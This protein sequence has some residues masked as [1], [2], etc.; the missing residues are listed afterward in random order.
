MNADT[1]PE[2]HLVERI[3]LGSVLVDNRHWADASQLSD[4]DFVLSGHQ[5]IFRRMRQLHSAGAEIDEMSLLLMLEQHREIDKVGGMAYIS[6]LGDGIVE[7]PNIQYFVNLL[8]EAAVKR[9]IGRRAELIYKEATNG[10]PLLELLQLV[11][12]LNRDIAPHSDAGLEVQPLKT[13]FAEPSIPTEYIWEGHLV[14]GTVSAVVAKPK[15]GKSTFARNLCLAVSKGEEFLGRATRKG[16]C[17]YLA[18]EERKQEVVADFRA[19]GANGEEDIGIFS[20]PTPV[21]GMA[22]LVRKILERKPCLVVID[23]LFRI[24]K[25]KDE[26]A[27]AETYAALGPLIEVARQ[28]NT[29]VLMTHHSGKAEKSDAIDSPLGST[30]I[31]GAVSSLIV[32]KRGESYRT[33]TTVQRVGNDLPEHVLHFNQETRLLTLGG[34][35]QDAERVACEELILEFLATVSEPQTQRQIRDAVEERR[36]VVY[37]ALKAL[38]AGG[39]VRKLG[40]G[41]RGEPFCYALPS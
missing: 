26:C 24:A 11:D 1:V 15:V 29:H 3:I 31:A 25:V 36:T 6:T 30:A 37:S 18:L 32:L 4:D 10:T 34:T 19:F 12:G 9:R 20:G 8:R 7:R 39:K 21:E 17:C 27:Y 28:T 40:T 35:K 5:I 41:K 23:P 14:V 22:L 13:L 2:D 16:E 38:E 33:I